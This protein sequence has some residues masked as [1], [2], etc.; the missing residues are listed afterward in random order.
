MEIYLTL[1]SASR[2]YLEHYIGDELERKSKTTK[3]MSASYLDLILATITPCTPQE[4]RKL[5]DLP[6][7]VVK[8]SLPDQPRKMSGGV[9]QCNPADGRSSLCWISTAKQAYLDS[10][11]RHLL[12]MECLAASQN[13]ARFKIEKKQEILMVLD[14]YGI[15]ESEF[16]TD[17]I[18]RW[19]T[20]QK[21]SISLC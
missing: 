12:R 21:Q 13:A 10:F 15:E 9:N 3:R 7:D 1:S 17:A 14:K 11:F 2:K 20:R 16:S 6:G 4:Y 18:L 19:I 5:S 8:L